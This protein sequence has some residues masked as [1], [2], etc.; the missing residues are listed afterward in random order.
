MQIER[1]VVMCY[2]NEIE[3]DIGRCIRALWSKKL[4]ILL[5]TLLFAV[6][7]ISLTIE[8]REDKYK[9][10]TTL[11]SVASGSYSESKT[12]ISAMNDYVDVATSHKVCQRAAYMLGRPDI[13]ASTVMKSIK[14]VENES[15]SSASSSAARLANDSAIII[16]TAVTND[17]NVSMQMADA[18]AE[19]FVMEMENIIGTA[20][21][22]I[23]DEAY[24]YEVAS[25]GNAERWKTRVLATAFGFII[26]CCMIVFFEIFDGYIRTI[27]EGSIRGELP[28]IGVIPEFK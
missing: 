16:I 14:V 28:I 9:A 26:S 1:K 20:S 12:G 13:D 21:V 5:I 24:D 11:Y 19:A 7:G 17:A 15:S 10:T 18:V 8:E 6:I 2:R 25:Y 27:R 23:L 22:Q 3:I 4:L